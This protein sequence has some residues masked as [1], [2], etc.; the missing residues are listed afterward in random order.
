MVP[1]RRDYTVLDTCEEYLNA[2]EGRKPTYI[3][4]KVVNA[5]ITPTLG[6]FSVEKLTR[7]RIEQ[8]LKQTAEKPRR[9]PLQRT[10]IE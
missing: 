8:W 6:T 5:V 4:R 9:E 7:A 1:R 10:E 3:P 2:L